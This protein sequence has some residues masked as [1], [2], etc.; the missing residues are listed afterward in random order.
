M[1]ITIT[2]L[3]CLMENLTA[4]HREP[5]VVTSYIVH[6][7]YS[8]AAKSSTSD[9]SL[10]TIANNEQTS[11]MKSFQVVH[12]SSRYLII[13]NAIIVIRSNEVQGDVLLRCHSRHVRL[14]E[15]DGKRDA[16]FRRCQISTL[17]SMISSLVRRIV[18]LFVRTIASNVI[19]RPQTISTKNSVI[20]LWNL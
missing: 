16:R 6:T 15:S 20:R 9:W 1:L 3:Q 12:K 18:V 4:Q 19:K 11:P 14:R 8:S 2:S 10:V 13:L 17:G 7:Q 5:L